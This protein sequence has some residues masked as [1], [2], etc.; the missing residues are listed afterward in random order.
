MPLHPAGRH[1]SHRMNSIDDLDHLLDD[2]SKWWFTQE[3][4]LLEVA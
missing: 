3:V 4:N 1:N 2:F